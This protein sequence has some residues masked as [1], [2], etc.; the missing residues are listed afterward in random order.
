MNK[1]APFA[2]L[3]LAGCSDA[4]LVGMDTQ[5]AIDGQVNRSIRYTPDAGGDA[6]DATCPSQ[7]DCE[8][9]ALCKARKFLAAGIQP[10][11]VTLV[12]VMRKH[13]SAHAV[14]V[15]NGVVFDNTTWPTP[16]DS[17]NDYTPVYGCRMDGQ[18]VAYFKGSIAGN[19][20][21]FG[22]SQITITPSG[23]CAAMFKSLKGETHVQR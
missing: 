22:Y 12:V 19:P 10:Q 8:D 7:G 4:R 13:A 21:L 11:D 1:L 9:Y 6:W 5:L 3:L 14:L 23:K 2:L 17:I 18:Q 16:A 20:Q 15:N